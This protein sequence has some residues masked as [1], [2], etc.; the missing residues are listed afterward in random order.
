MCEAVGL[1]S[2]EVTE[3]GNLGYPRTNIAKAGLVGGPCLEK[4]PHILIHGLAKYDFKPTLITS[5]RKLNEDLPKIAISKI[6]PL[7]KFKNTNFKIALCGMAF[8]GV[9]E[10]DDLLGL[11]EDQQ[12][13]FLDAF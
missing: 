3:A 6:K 10:T 4:D 2:T 7:L 12:R 9:P 13:P 1:D 5:G 11:N 8:K